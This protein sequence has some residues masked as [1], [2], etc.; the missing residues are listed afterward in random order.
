MILNEYGAIIENQWKMIMKKYPFVVLDERMVM[1]NH[2]HAIIGFA[3]AV[4]AGLPRPHESI[5]DRPKITL[6]N[7][8]GY[9][10]YQTTKTIN[11]IRGSE[12]VRLWQRN[13]HERIIRDEEELHRIREYIRN[14]PEQWET[15]ELR[16]I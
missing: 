15:D 7:V 6:G 4:R 16:M 5:T 13:Y 10:K 9:F 11:A 12:R 14:N 1:P 2:F 8:M 3:H